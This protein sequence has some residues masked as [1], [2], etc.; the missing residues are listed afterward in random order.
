MPSV[1]LYVYECIH[2]H[3]LQGVGEPALFL[4]ASVFFAIKEA[5]ASARTERGVSGRF[6][7]DSPA[8]CERI[9]MACSDQFTK[10]VYICPRGKYKKN[11]LIGTCTCMSFVYQERCHALINTHLMLRPPMAMMY[12]CSCLHAE[13]L[14]PVTS[15]VTER[16]VVEGE[17]C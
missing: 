9:R 3:L 1:Q 4:A 11:S 5:I 6:L 13:S 8:T 16:T 7:L 10:Q 17:Y 15:S 12:M 14:C 2:P